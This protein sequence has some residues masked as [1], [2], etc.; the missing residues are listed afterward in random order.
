M[1]KSPPAKVG[2]IRDMGSIPGSERSP[3]EGNG[4]PLQCSCL[5]NPM[6]RGAGWATVHRVT[7]SR[8]WLKW[9]HAPLS[10]GVRKRKGGKRRTPRE[11]DLESF[12]PQNLHAHKMESLKPLTMSSRVWGPSWAHRPSQVLLLTAGVWGGLSRGQCRWSGCVVRALERLAVNS[13][14]DWG[15]LDG[16]SY[17]WEVVE[18]S[19]FVS[20]QLFLQQAW[21]SEPKHFHL[22]MGDLV[23]M[24]CS[25]LLWN[26]WD[27]KE[28]FLI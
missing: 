24:N 7:K 25:I 3:G 14:G 12:F 1:V 23:C 20:P 10:K 17:A 4:Y 21:W 13:L 6:D 9:Q 28:A 11:C 19:L 22:L 8:T 18:R 27:S 2:D 5:K 26:G 16:S 15:L